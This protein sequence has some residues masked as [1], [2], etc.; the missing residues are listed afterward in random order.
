MKTR[1]F[2]L[3]LRFQIA[4]P[5][6]IL[7]I[8]VIVLAFGFG[9]P[10]ARESTQEEVDLKLDN[11]RSLFLISMHHEE[12][13]LRHAAALLGG[14]EEIAGALA[15]GDR[16][17]LESSLADFPSRAAVD[18]LQVFDQS[19]AVLFDM[20]GFGPVA[21]EALA[22][23]SEQASA[24]GSA[25]GLVST[26]AGPV[27][28]AVTPVRSSAGPQGTI[29]VGQSLSRQLQEMRQ[30]IGGELSLYQN[31]RL[32]ASTFPLE[33]GQPPQEVRATSVP[34]A[35]SPE[36]GEKGLVVG[37]HAYT[38]AYGS[39]AL[40]G[41]PAASFAVF[42][43]KSDVWSVDTLVAVGVTTALVASLGLL[44]LGF[45]TARHIAARLERV[46][47][48]IEK[49]GGG[50]LSQRVDIDS[51]DEIGRLGQ[52]VN[53]MTSKL[54]E[55]ES[56]KA[57][58]LAMASHELRT[59]LALMKSSTE[60][61]LDGGNGRA[62]P[63][64]RELLQIVA[65]NI[66]RMNRRVND[67]LDLARLQAGHLALDIQP[68]DLRRLVKEVAE[69]A[70]SM[71]TAK[72]QALSLVLPRR[73]APVDVDPDRIQQVLLNLLSNASRHTPANSRIVVQVAEKK[74]LVMVAVRDSGPG[75]PR[76]QLGRLFD[77][78]RR[79]PSKNGAGLGL[80]IAQRLVHLH[81][82]EIWAESW[83][84]QGSVFAFAIP[85]R[86]KKGA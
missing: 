1:F 52:V 13:Q 78:S 76:E 26:T 14:D 80:L 12:D 66:E 73:L 70:R 37:G 86:G 47:A 23:L 24:S 42:L 22:G 74:D 58:F 15:A 60:L 56:S 33:H 31:G 46:V 59:P 54:Q 64:R 72:E 34:M 83:P 57:E 63:A 6:S 43:P 85:R 41:E 20:G 28:V 81:G 75:I 51:S 27:M 29:V 65:G 4:I 69:S 11:A 61:L 82:G 19:G 16:R 49:V 84:G 25:T 79:S 44:V 30:A 48:V 32:L 38:V 7:I 68:T 67:L 9:L 71:M 36:V 21:A 53:L 45:L 3:P 2:D 10:L 62:G 8:G 55:V 35:D 39:L 40:G 5:F 50:D 18:A 17:G 77:R